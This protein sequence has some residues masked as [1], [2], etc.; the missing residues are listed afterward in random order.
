MARLLVAD[1]QAYAESLDYKVVKRSKGYDIVAVR[2][3]LGA[4]SIKH[5]TKLEDVIRAIKDGVMLIGD[6]SI[7]PD[8]KITS[9]ESE[10]DK[11]DDDEQGY[12]DRGING[13]IIKCIH[14]RCEPQCNYDC[15]QKYV[16]NRNPISTTTDLPGTEQQGS[17]EQQRNYS[18]N[19]V[20]SA[21]SMDSY[22]V[23][24]LEKCLQLPEVESTL[25]DV[26]R[27]YNDLPILVEHIDRNADFEE[28][29]KTINALA[30]Y[31]Y[32]RHKAKGRG[33]GR[34]TELYSKMSMANPYKETFIPWA[35]DVISCHK[36]VP[37]KA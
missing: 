16:A 25:E 8:T 22:A 28:I 1:V 3:S 37:V 35:M 26:I 24:L 4:K 7:V 31:L 5:V 6:Y 36:D 11:K 30:G 12:R 14:P 10:Q 13:A 29:R 32:R 18:Y 9:Q 20:T 17:I 27:E 19:V 23:P 21:P 15:E 2:P 34:I 33:C